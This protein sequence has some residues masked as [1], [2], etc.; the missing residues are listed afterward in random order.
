MK[1]Q[2]AYNEYKGS[3]L[4][5]GRIPTAI[6]MK[7]YANKNILR[8]ALTEGLMHQDKMSSAIIANEQIIEKFLEKPSFDVYKPYFDNIKRYETEL[9][10][11]REI[12]FLTTSLTVLNNFLDAKCEKTKQHMK[13]INKFVDM[14]KTITESDSL[15]I[16]S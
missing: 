3:G 6:E 12:E 2:N 9:E 16:S 5:E 14:L 1:V 7:F 4:P 15:S 13:D 8:G 10:I 11:K